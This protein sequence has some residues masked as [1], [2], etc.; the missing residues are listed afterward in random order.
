MRRAVGAALKGTWSQAAAVAIATLGRARRLEAGGQ[1]LTDLGEIVLI[2]FKRPYDLADGDGL[3][4]ESGGYVLI[5][6]ADEAYARVNCTDAELLA[7]VSWHLGRRG[8]RIELVPDALYMRDDPELIA[9]AQ[10][11]GAEV[12]VVAHAFDPEREM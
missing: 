10:G 2:A 4:L 1:L 8:E 7:R 6:V 5:R 12:E 9:L 3:L 11:V